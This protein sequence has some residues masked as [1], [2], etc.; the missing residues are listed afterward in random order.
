MMHLPAISQ[1]VQTPTMISASLPPHSDSSNQLVDQL[2]ERYFES[3][4]KDLNDVKDCIGQKT[5]TRGSYR[6][7]KTVNCSL[8]L[9]TIHEIGIAAASCKSAVYEKAM[10]Q[11]QRCDKL[12]QSRWNMTASSRP[13][14]ISPRMPKRSLDIKCIMEV[15]MSIVEV[16]DD[17]DFLIA[18]DNDQLANSFN[19]N[20]HSSRAKAA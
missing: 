4:K 5:C 16:A 6:S 12:E 14:D 11:K 17:N 19:Q 2:D 13:L 20:M 1:K 9:P 10:L 15:A 7:K 3:F 8:P 18:R